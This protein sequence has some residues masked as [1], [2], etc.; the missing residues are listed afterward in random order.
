MGLWRVRN[1]AAN[2]AAH[3]I[4]SA[5]A[6]PCNTMAPRVTGRRDRAVLER[7]AGH[8]HGDDACPAVTVS[9]R[10]PPWAFADVDM[11]RRFAV[12]SSATGRGATEE[13]APPSSRAGLGEESSP[14]TLARSHHQSGAGPAEMPATG[15]ACTF[16]CGGQLHMYVGDGSLCPSPH[17]PDS[18]CWEKKRHGR[19]EQTE[20]R[21]C[22]I[23]LRH[24]G[25]HPAWHMH[26]SEARVSY[27]EHYWQHRPFTEGSKAA[28]LSMLELMTFD[29]KVTL[30]HGLELH[31]YVG[32]TAP[33]ERLGIPALALNDGPQGF[34]DPIGSGAAGT[35]TA[36]PCGK[37]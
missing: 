22:N 3:G 33:I 1:Q 31:Q 18:W 15:A 24:D 21:R 37:H 6:S 26:V 10:F 14:M 11:I 25:P 34:R 16:D 7:H 9:T 12:P 35:S 28:A 5:I 32:E 19:C 36:F 8:G 27:D 20:G 13:G 4:V 2:S 17:T 23:F 29:E 30:L